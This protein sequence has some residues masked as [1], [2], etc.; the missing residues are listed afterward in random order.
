MAQFKALPPGSTIGIIGNGQLG[1]MTALAAARLG[2]AC[3]VFGPDADSPAEQVAFRAT[4]AAYDDKDALVEFAKSVDV[5]TFEFENIPHESVQLLTKHVEVR[6][7]WNCLQIS[8]DRL[9]E[10]TFINDCGIDT[11]PFKAVNSLADLEAAVEELGRPSILKTTRMGYDG[12]G[13]ALIRPETDLE[14]AYDSMA[15][16]P[17]VL[18]GFVEFQREISVIVARSACGQ[19]TAFE[20]A[21]NVHVDGIL[22]TSSVPAHI[23]D[24]LVEEAVRIAVTLAEKMDIIGLLAVEMFH[25]KDDRLIVN[26]VAPRPHNSGHWT[27]DAC[28]SDQFEQFVRAVCGLPLGSVERRNDL[29]MKN[30]IGFDVEKW[31]DYLNEP[32]A[33]LHLY[34]KA[35][36][37]RGRKMGHVNLVYPLGELPK[38]K[39]A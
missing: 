20:P 10:K 23:P 9:I 3:H 34:G 18:E 27:Q 4:V 17:S 33:K 13:Q 31:P 37:R 8:Q 15:G 11:A 19:W 14:T 39:K 38:S 6:P 36:T 28:Y 29:V 7:G 21:E 5:V 26:E 12:K 35:S 24:G 16:A 32:N 2:Y 25:T 30:L 1:R 22:D